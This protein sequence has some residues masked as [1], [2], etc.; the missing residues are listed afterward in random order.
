VTGGGD[1]RL[2]VGLDAD[3]LIYAAMPD[4]ALGPRIRGFLA[5]R[6]RYAFCGSTLLLAEVLI[7]PTRAKDVDQL[8]RLTAQLSHIELWPATETVGQLAVWF[9]ATYRLGPMDAMHLA[10]AVDRGADV[11]LTNNRK[12]FRS[13]QIGAIDVIYPEELPIPRRRR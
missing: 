11:F 8:A 2:V 12:D 6:D 13:A 9:G 4:H 3:V 5:Q 7:K 1:D 10:T